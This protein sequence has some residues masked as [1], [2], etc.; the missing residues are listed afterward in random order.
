MVQGA[1]G[2]M[3]NDAKKTKTKQNAKKTRAKKKR[4]THC[5]AGNKDDFAQ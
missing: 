3:S 5:R 2:R 1:C 4:V